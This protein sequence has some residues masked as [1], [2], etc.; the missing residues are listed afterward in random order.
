MFLPNEMWVVSMVAEKVIPRDRDGSDHFW[1]DMERSVFIAV[2]EAVCQ[3]EAP[4]NELKRACGIIKEGRAAVIG[5]IETTRP[6]L[7]KALLDIG[8]KTAISVFNG[9][10]FHT[11]QFA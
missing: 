11:Q 10:I 1:S 3:E 4:A 8:E 7:A 6:D 9:L 2:L 5:Y